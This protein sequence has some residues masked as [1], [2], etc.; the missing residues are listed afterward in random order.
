MDIKTCIQRSPLQ[1]KTEKN[2]SQIETTRKILVEIL[3]KEFAE[4]DLLVER[5]KENDTE[6]ID[7]IAENEEVI[8]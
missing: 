8:E 5:T 4:T 3:T 2:L 6:E 1:I 7:H